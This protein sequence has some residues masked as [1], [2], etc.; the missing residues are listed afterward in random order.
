MRLIRLKF[1]NRVEGEGGIIINLVMSRRVFERMGIF[2]FRN[3]RHWYKG[4]F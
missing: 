4:E 3:H 2:L 1:R